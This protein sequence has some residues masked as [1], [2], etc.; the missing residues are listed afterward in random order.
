MPRTFG[1][2]LA[3]VIG[4][5]LA[6]A[7]SPFGAKGDAGDETGTRLE[8][9]FHEMVNDYR[10][11]RNLIELQRDAALDAVARA[12]SRDMA[13]RRYL[14]HV[15]PEGQNPL[16]RIEAAGIAGFTLAAE[17]AGQT[18]RSDLNR[19]ILEGWIASPVHRRNL[20]APPFNRTGIGI[21]RAPDGTWYF[22]QLYITVPR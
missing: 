14:A 21:A 2:G 9:R 5:G 8:A 16:D 12:H 13:R 10:R 4:F 17:N 15:N 3:F 6:L 11:G 18:D 20:H 7:L 22:T 1:Q 19:E